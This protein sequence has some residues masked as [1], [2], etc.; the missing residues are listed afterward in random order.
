[1]VFV[2]P[3]GM[4]QLLY[5]FA[6]LSLISCGPGKKTVQT[7][8]P[9]IIIGEDRFQEFAP[10]RLIIMYDEKTGKDPLLKALKDYN[11]EIIYDYDFISGMAIK[12]PDGSD[13][14]KAIKYFKAVKGVVSVERDRIIRLTD[15]VKPKVV[16]M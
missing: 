10:D 14:K 8:E 7:L 12:I 16:I 15:P 5:I 2:I 9:Q 3:W 13:I 1:M 4:K 11:A 6:F